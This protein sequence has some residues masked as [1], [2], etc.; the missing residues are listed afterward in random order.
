MFRTDDPVR[1]LAMEG[2]AQNRMEFDK[3]VLT[4]SAG[5]IALMVGL[6]STVGARSTREMWAF[7]GSIAAFAAAA[8][9]VLMIFKRNADYC[10]R[11]LC[12][13]T[14]D[15]LVLKWGDRIAAVAFMAGVALAVLGAGAINKARPAASFPHTTEA[16]MPK[17]RATQPPGQPT[18]TRSLNG[19]GKLVTPSPTTGASGGGAAVPTSPTAGSSS[20][21]PASAGAATPKR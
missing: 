21:P 9:V 10:A 20:Q 15:D 4:L 1:T 13:D 18:E 5:G 11:Y 7:Y 8:G 2:W 14:R 12:G 6:L 19:L 3:S 17:N 16:P